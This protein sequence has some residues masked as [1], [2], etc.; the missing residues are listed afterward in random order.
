MN[1]DQ[2]TIGFLGVSLVLVA[3]VMA[4]SSWVKPLLFQPDFVS[5]QPASI[6]PL[7]VVGSA[8]AVTIG[9]TSGIS[10]STAASV[11]AKI[12]KAFPGGLLP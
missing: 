7:G 6:S 10:S 5:N 3:F 11:L 9:A 2:Q 4:N 1:S 12:K 8:L